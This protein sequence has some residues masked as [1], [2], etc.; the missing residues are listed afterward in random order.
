VCSDIESK[1]QVYRDTIDRIDQ[2]ILELMNDRIVAAQAIGEIKKKLEQ[3]A[4]YRPE[5][6]AQVLRRLKEL[7]AGPMGNSDVESLFREIMSIARGTEAD[8][9]VSLLGPAGTFSESAT[10]KHFGSTI[11]LVHYSSIDEIFKAA[12][13][14]QTD[15]AVVPIENSTEGGV[16]ATLDRLTSTSLLICGEI[17]LKV[18]HNLISQASSLDSVQRVM[19]HPQAFAQCRQW[20]GQN[21]PGVDLVPCSS[22]AAAVEHA[23]EDPAVAGI[24]ADTAAKNFDLDILVANIE[25]EPGN[26]TRFLVLSDRNTP[27]S[28]D[29]KTSL[30]VSGRNRPGALFHLLKPLVNENLDMTKIE[31]RPSRSGLWEYIFF[32]D[33]KGHIE[34]PIVTRAINAI[35]KE[36]GLFR[37]LGSYPD[38]KQQR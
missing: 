9:S 3:P 2:Q 31:S 27:I 1:L 8:F 23:S 26:T 24:A 38:G 13:T 7:N 4:F 18:H 22:N 29:D 25:D 6:E 36:A 10:L 37:H 11:N 15:F 30:L 28:G 16:S 20:L 35:K 5:R 32:V 33:V 14:G 21:M 12:E 17:Y 34:D 19:A